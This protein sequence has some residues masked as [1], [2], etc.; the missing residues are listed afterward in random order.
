MNYQQKYLKYKNKY[1]QLK[2]QLGGLS[3]S[4][5]M[6]I[7][8]MFEIVNRKFTGHITDECLIELK[9]LR[10]I[11]S[12]LYKELSEKIE[13]GESIEDSELLK[14]EYILDFAENINILIESN[15]INIKNIDQHI[16]KGLKL[17]LR[18]LSNSPIF[19]DPESIATLNRLSI[20]NLLKA[21][22]D[23]VDPKVCPNEMS[24]HAIDNIND[25][26]TKIDCTLTPNRFF[27]NIIDKYY[28]EG[29]RIFICEIGRGEERDL[30]Y[31]FNRFT[32]PSS[33]FYHEKNNVCVLNFGSYS[34][35]SEYYNEQINKKDTAT[36]YG[37]II[38]I[39]T[40][41]MYDHH[42][43]DQFNLWF[44]QYY[45]THKIYLEFCD[46]IGP[47]KYKGDEDIFGSKIMPNV[48]FSLVKY[49]YDP[50]NRF[51]ILYQYDSGDYL[52]TNSGNITKKIIKIYKELY[53]EL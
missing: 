16:G 43:I 5:N 52:L 19:L 11:D 34:S 26:I 29:Y 25:S 45:A 10:S 12:I 22:M 17:L 8:G 48:F 23:A 18:Q 38:Y 39:N 49:N 24:E 35:Q 50:M 51:K 3:K 40:Y 41:Y 6:V 47:S 27:D 33:N 13:A 30:Q 31:I 21:S 28:Q 7:K 44:P 20:S 36:L 1:S 37:N 2:K 15:I 9:K 32:D 42:F 53:T 46:M 14:Y 4:E